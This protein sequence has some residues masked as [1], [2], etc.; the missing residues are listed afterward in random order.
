VP[1]A[2]SS[3][4]YQTPLMFLKEDLVIATDGS[5]SPSTREQPTIIPRPGKAINR[6]SAFH[7]LGVSPSMLRVAH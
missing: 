4:S 6:W 7:F 1:S 2:E 5:T 3:N